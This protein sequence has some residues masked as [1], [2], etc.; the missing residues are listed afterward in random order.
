M[1]IRLVWVVSIVSGALL[2]FHYAVPLKL[3]MY[4][5]FLIAF[6][7]IV[8]A[9]QGF[10]RVAGLASMTVLVAILLPVIGIVQLTKIGSPSLAL[11]QVLHVVIGVAAIGLAEVL[12]KRLGAQA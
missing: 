2:Y 5:G 3:H 10:K 1:T 11:W 4:L 12:G 8:L 6:L 9:V 7:M